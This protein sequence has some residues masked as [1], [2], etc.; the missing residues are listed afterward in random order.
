M[1]LEPHTMV[2]AYAL[3]ALEDDEREAFEVHV[4]RCPEC[5]DELAGFLETAS[6]L[7]AATEGAPPAHLRGQ[8]LTARKSVV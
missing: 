2:G 8:I 1:T 4:D 3:D 5:T 6:R 7:G